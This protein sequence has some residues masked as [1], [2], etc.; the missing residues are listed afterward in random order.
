MAAFHPKQT[1][2]LASFL[3]RKPIIIARKALNLLFVAF[4]E[5]LVSS[6]GL[7]I[8]GHLRPSSLNLLSME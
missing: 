3:L 2:P 1:M 4:G 7:F 5:F 8:F 6:T